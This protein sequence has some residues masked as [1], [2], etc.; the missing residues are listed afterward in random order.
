MKI[1]VIGSGGREHAILRA[2]WR[3]PD[4][5]KLYAIPGNGGMSEAE[6]VPGLKASDLD[7]IVKFSR[8]KELDYVVVSPDEP[9][10]LGLVDRLMEAG[11]PA[12]GP[13]RSAAL[14]EGS[15]V[16]AKEFM[17]RHGI[18][19]ADYRVFSELSEAEKYIEDCELPIVIKADGLALGKGVIIAKSREEARIGLWSIMGEKKFGHS[20]DRVVVEEYLEGPEV[21]VLSFT[22]G[23]RIVPMLSSMDHKRALDGDL[24]PNTGG[25]GVI[26]PNP[27]Y[28]EEIAGECM[29]RILL[30][31]IRGMKEEGRIFRGC[32]YF[33]LMLSGK[34]PKVIEYNCR[35]GDPE[36]Q[37]VLP[38]LRSDLLPILLSCTRGELSEELVRWKAGHSCCVILASDGYP[39]A[40]ESGYEITGTKLCREVYMAGVERKEGRLFSSGGRVLGVVGTGES[41]PAAIESAYRD[42][43]K[44]YFK[45]MR[46]RRDIGARALRLMGGEDGI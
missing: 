14:L 27:C 44:V 37:A 3:S 2:L 30:P 8:E 19:S 43:E 25:M 15:K 36:A 39:G 33:G 16:F 45:N 46:Y 12:F 31:T 29:E 35:F 1:G 41:L 6:T 5:E 40:F 18:P 23:E 26:A 10:V 17:K 28:T 21:S 7:G 24:G 20:G 34:G 22:D 38:L 32:L 42:V 9:L 4:C 13:S 11:L